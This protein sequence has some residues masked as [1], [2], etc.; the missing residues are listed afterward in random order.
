MPYDWAD[1]PTIDTVNSQAH[2]TNARHSERRACTPSGRPRAPWGNP[3]YLGGFRMRRRPGEI[4]D[5][6]AKGRGRKIKGYT[7]PDSGTTRL[8]SRG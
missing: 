7:T 5:I 4:G 1:D 6:L 2:A 8:G 3:R